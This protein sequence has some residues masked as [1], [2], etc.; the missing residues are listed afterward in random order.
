EVSE[1]HPEKICE[2]R[3]CKSQSLVLEVV[4]VV[5]FSSSKLQLN[6]SARHLAQ[7]QSLVSSALIRSAYVWQKVL[8]YCSFSFLDSVF[9]HLSV[10]HTIPYEQDSVFGVVHSQ[11]F[12][13]GRL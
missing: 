13:V 11:R 12:F 10:C 5:R 9:F 1:G 2:Q 4:L 8:V 3:P 6:C 7:E